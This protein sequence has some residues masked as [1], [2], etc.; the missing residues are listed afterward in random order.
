MSSIL[1]YVSI[2]LL[3]TSYKSHFIRKS[4][5]KI[6]AFGYA[7]DHSMQLSL[8]EMQAILGLGQVWGASPATGLS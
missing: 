6:P 3:L 2:L 4:P 1:E 5:M 7:G 8:E